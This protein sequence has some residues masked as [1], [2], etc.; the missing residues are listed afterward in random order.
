MA[1]HRAS[2]IACSALL[3]LLIH[4]APTGACAQE[5]ST[6]ARARESERQMTDVGPSVVEA[7]AT[8]AGTLPCAS[9]PGIE[10]TL[11]L[12]EDG[13][14]R[15]RRVY[16]EAEEGEDLPFVE[17]GRWDTGG[18]NDRVVLR[19]RDEGPIR[20]EVEGA[21]T[22]RLLDQQ[23][24][25]IESMFDYTLRRL[26]AVD[27]IAD[28]FPMRGEFSYMADAGW[29]SECRTRRRL[30]V[31]QEADNAALERAYS[32]T[33]KEPGAPVLVTFDGRFA[34]RPPMEGEGLHEVVIV[35]AF[36]EARPG[37]RCE[38]AVDPAP[39]AGTYW[40]LADLPGDEGFAVDP[41][42]RAH[43]VLGG[44]EGRV[45]GSSGCN[46]L[47]G[48]FTL[49][50]DAL[51]FGPLAG[52]RMACPQPAMELERRFYAALASV[53]GYAIDGEVLTLEGPDGPVARF[54]RYL[55]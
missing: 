5:R 9:C 10:W 44:E 11:T 22:L 23:G 15:L 33:R 16:L 36:G 14:Y 7:P 45:S 47:I 34:M 19:G 46:R 48:T 4:V 20:L 21:E 32:V 2:F 49:D 40:R 30:P 31:A 27:R 17:V 13:T 43:L 39:L 6:D 29:F 53:T 35:E 37:E 38:G 52:T 42:L 28:V 12:L 18:R 8:Y 1:R 54:E 26:A 51:S 41:G 25:P 24:Q 55:E 50:G 3:L